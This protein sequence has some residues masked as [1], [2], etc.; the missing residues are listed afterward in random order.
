VGYAD[1]GLVARLAM[2]PDPLLYFAG[3]FGSR[4]RSAGRL[5]AMLTEWLGRPVVAEQF[6]GAWVEIGRDQ[7]T[8]LPRGG[9][10]QFNRLGVEAAVGARAWDVRSQLVLRVGPLD[11]AQFRALLPG[12]KLP[13]H[14]EAFVRA[15]LGPEIKVVINP[16][17][18][19]PAVPAASLGEAAACFLGWTSWLPVSGGRKTHADDARFRLG[20]SLNRA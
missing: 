2:G 13:T 14:L 8:R 12:G 7:M 16:V 4:P 19:A 1:P 10:G 15:Y 18:A 11:E 5:A 20:R 6:S 9:I 3:L 17:L